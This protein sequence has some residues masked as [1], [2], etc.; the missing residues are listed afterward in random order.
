MK[1][2]IQE[3]L[4]QID[5]SDA[6]LLVAGLVLL[7]LPVLWFIFFSGVREEKI[8]VTRISFANPGR[9]SAFNLTN[10]GK[11]AVSAVSRSSAATIQTPNDKLE[12]ELSR[13]W[14][15]ISSVPRRP[16]IPPD[17]PPEARQMIEAEDDVFLSEG[18]ASLD[19]CDFPAA[20]KAFS[21][22]LGNADGNT[23]KELY[24]Y[25]GLMQ[26]YQMQA[27]VA[28]FRQAFGN[29]ARTAQKL[30]DV[31]GPLADNVA[32]AYEMFEQLG[33]I[34]SGKLREYLTRTNLTNKTAVSYEEFMS[35]INNTKKWFPADL[36]S[37]EPRMPSLLKPNDGG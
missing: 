29:Y 17:T 13:A 3:N 36:E 15:K 9:Q 37:P 11:V 31:Y 28:K 5:L 4:E 34:D 16:S 14:S 19:R 8:N 27:D 7:I 35:A 23:F 24:A 32:R 22:L 18:N 30:R 33:D 26:I 25:G 20:E 21:S 10:P 6:R 2:Q 1:K 12:D